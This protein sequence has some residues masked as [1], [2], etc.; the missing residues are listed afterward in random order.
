MP[1][2]LA[3][4][5][6]DGGLSCE[7]GSQQSKNSF[8]HEHTLIFNAVD[9]VTYISDHFRKDEEDQQVKNNN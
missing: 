9:S 7:S 3:P 6:S 1:S 5:I 8:Q 2:S 4:S